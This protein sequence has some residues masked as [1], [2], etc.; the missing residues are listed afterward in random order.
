MALDPFRG[1]PCPVG[2]FIELARGDRADRA[3]APRAMAEVVLM[4]VAGL[5]PPGGG[6]REAVVAIASETMAALAVQKRCW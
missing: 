3:V 6:G 4:G 2:D 5:R 1:R